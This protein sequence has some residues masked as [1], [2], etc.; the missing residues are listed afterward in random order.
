MSRVQRKDFR[1]DTNA[2]AYL[3]S[4]DGWPLGECEMKDVSNS[5][6]KLVH[7][8]DDEMPPSFF[9]SL[10][11]NG[12]VRRLCEVAWKKENQIGVRFVKGA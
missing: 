1:K 10:S 3:Y 11:R 6:A 12:Q 7:K 2:V 5:G 8:I 4:I 9:L